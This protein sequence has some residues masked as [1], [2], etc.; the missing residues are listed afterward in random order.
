[1]RSRPG[2]TSKSPT[3]STRTSSTRCAPSRGVQGP[4]AR[5]LPRSGLARGAALP[6]ARARRAAHRAA[7]RPREADQRAALH[8]RR[9]AHAIRSRRSGRTSSAPGAT[10]ASRSS[11]TTSR[12]IP[13]AHA[14]AAPMGPSLSRTRRRGGAGHHAA[15][16][17]CCAWC[18][19]SATASSCTRDCCP[20]CS[21]PRGRG[22]IAG[23]F[24]AAVFWSGLSGVVARRHRRGSV[25]RVLRRAHG[26]RPRLQSRRPA[27]DLGRRVLVRRRRLRRR[28]RG[29]DLPRDARRLADHRVRDP[30]RHG[31]DL[32]RGAA[33][34]L[35][36]PRAWA[37][38]SSGSPTGRGW[39]SAAST[40]TRTRSRGARSRRRFVPGLL[41]MSLAVVNAI[42]DYPPGPPRRQ[43]QPRRAPR[44]RRRRA[45]CTCRWRPPASRSRRSGAGSAC[46]P[47]GCLAALLAASAA[48]RERAAR[49][50]HVHHPAPIRACHPQHRC[51]LRRGG[52]AVHARRA[53][54]S[55][56][57]DGRPS[58]PT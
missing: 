43:A 11:S 42:P 20:T 31:G 9:P 57:G 30:R 22:R 56:V 18:R 16:A 15:A 29:R 28:A 55:A 40:C 34:P 14:H 41:I 10:R 53:G 4:H 46:F 25:Q 32:L 3:S 1:M 48:R 50:R 6:P 19:W 27:A 5:V 47:A 38:S 54:A 8:L 2:A 36:L 24:D 39:C 52:H 49:P 7:Q 37:S 26:H 17:A 45:C 23:T 44:T 58:E 51:V 21:A 12:A 33:D 13:A 35:V